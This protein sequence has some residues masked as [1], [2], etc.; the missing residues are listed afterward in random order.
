MNREDKSQVSIDIEL[1]D[2]VHAITEQM[3]LTTTDVNQIEALQK[4]FLQQD[5]KNY[6]VSP[7]EFAKIYDEKYGDYEW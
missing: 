7:E 5:V 4:A 2:E 3:D 6:V 1:K